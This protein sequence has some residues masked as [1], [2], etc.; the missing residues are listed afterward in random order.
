[1]NIQMNIHLN[2]YMNI[3]DEIEIFISPKR[4]FKKIFLFSEIFL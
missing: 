1:M 4:I 2:I 3:C